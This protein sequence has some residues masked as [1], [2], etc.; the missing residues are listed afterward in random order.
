MIYC[1]NIVYDEELKNKLN[2]FAIYG[3]R[4]VGRK[5]YEYMEING[6]EGQVE[7][8]CDRDRELQGKTYHGVPVIEPEKIIQNHEIHILVGGGAAYEKLKYLTEHNFK[9][10]HILEL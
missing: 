2:R 1:G 8:F 3:A 7:Y 5:I 9:N 4:G 10:V 6:L